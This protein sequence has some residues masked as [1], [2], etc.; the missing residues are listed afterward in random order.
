MAKNDKQIITE[1]FEKQKS[2]NRFWPFVFFLCSE[3]EKPEKV[4]LNIL[5]IQR[6]E[7]KRFMKKTSNEIP[8]QEMADVK[9]C[10]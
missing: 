2:S 6:N 1:N 5:D 9:V 7:K 8:L 3:T 4:V 10:E